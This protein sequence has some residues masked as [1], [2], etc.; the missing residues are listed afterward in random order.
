MWRQRSVRD[1]LL[2]PLRRLH[3]REE[4]QGAGGEERRAA[5]QGEG[6]EVAQEAAA[7]AAAAQPPPIHAAAA[8][9]VRGGGA[10]GLLQAVRPL[11]RRRH[12]AWRGTGLSGKLPWLRGRGGSGMRILQFR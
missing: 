3:L 12:A 11:L 4:P 8:A 7:A 2:Q 5:G 1:R 6:A 10:A 9:D